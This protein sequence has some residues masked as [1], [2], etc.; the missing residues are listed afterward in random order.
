MKKSESFWD[1]KINPA[2]NGPVSIQSVTSTNREF[3]LRDHVVRSWGELGVGPLEGLD[4]N[5]GNPLG[6]GELQE[7][8]NDGRRQIASSIYPLHG[9]TVVT[10]TLVEKILLESIEGELRA[11][12]I[13]LANGTDFRGSNVLLAAGAIRSPQILMLSGV[14]PADELAKVGVSV[15]LD[16]PAVGKNL[17]DHGLFA[18][19][20]N[21]KD[22]CAGWAIGSDNPL[23][24]REQYGWGGP[25]DFLTTTDVPKGGLAAAIEEDEGVAPDP[26][27][28]PLLSGPRAFAEHVFM[29]AG[30]PDGS[31]VTFVLITLLPTARG[32]IKLASASIS[33]PPLIDPNFLGSAVDRSVTREAMKTQLKF[34]TSTEVGREILD[35]E[36]GAPGFDQVFTANSTDEYIDARLRAGLG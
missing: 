20:W 36:V 29:Y 22:P 13:K 27:T 12:G 35:G 26:A 6:I 15:V 16:Q 18:H 14:G 28:H 8:K 25:M 34:A 23:F 33:D 3:P 11:T 2:H 19:V 24:D 17:S 21:V 1:K 31:K 32:S 10:D 30:A 4:A 9:A 7:N 5:A